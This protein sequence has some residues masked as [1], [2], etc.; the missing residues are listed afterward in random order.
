MLIIVWLGVWCWLKSNLGTGVNYCL[1]GGGV[2]AQIN[3]RDKCKLL[4]GWGWGFGSN[5]P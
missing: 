3:L 2:L 5:Q 4:F 1:V